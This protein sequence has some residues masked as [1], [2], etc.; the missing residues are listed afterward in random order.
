MSRPSRSRRRDTGRPRGRHVTDAVL[1]ATL[2]E[3]AVA[4][5]E[6]LSIERVAHEAEVHKTT[7]YRRWPT[8]EALVA[9][10]LE[11]I[12]DD[13][14]ARTPNTGT[15][16]GDLLAL[17]GQV[18]SFLAQPTGRAV[19]RAALSAQAEGQVAA[20][21]ARRIELG[22]SGAVETLALRARARG[23]WRDGPS[24]ELVIPTLVGA[25]MHRALLEHADLGPAWLEALVD[26]V[27]LGVTPRA[28][29]TPGAG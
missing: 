26:L 1:E 16:R 12:A 29:A 8:R 23:E 13:L 22:T 15:L 21:A 28:G 19:A 14:V 5:I 2:A 27:L 10:A 3:L 11:G 9:A 25:L 20:L 18:A 4:G 7:V 6:G 17:L 24:P